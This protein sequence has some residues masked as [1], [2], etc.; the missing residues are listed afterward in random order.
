MT[1]KLD[2]DHNLL[3][4]QV[5]RYW[6]SGDQQLLQNQATTLLLQEGEYLWDTTQGCD[7]NTLLHIGNPTQITRAL[8]SELQLDPAISYVTITTQPTRHPSTLHLDISIKT[9]S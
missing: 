2:R 7:F 9:T 1:P 3:Y 4:S 6:L 8:H 5:G